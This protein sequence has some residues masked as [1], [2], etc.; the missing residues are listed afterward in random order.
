MRSSNQLRSRTSLFPQP[1]FVSLLG[2]LLYEGKSNEAYK[3]LEEVVKS[4]AEELVLKDVQV[5]HV[6]LAE[7]FERQLNIC[8]PRIRTAFL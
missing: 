7:A 5:R 8:I 3:R 2:Q 4:R 1:C 6:I